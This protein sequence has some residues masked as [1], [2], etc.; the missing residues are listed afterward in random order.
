[1]LLY[2]TGTHVVVVVPHRCTCSC[3]CTTQVHML[4]FLL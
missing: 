3:C 1:L 4:L 2:H